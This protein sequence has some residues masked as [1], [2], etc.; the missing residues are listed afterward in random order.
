MSKTKEMTV[1]T[2][3]ASKIGIP[4]SADLHSSKIKQIA[5]NDGNFIV[6]QSASDL[7]KANEILFKFGS[8]DNKLIDPANCY[9][10][11]YGQI[12]YGDGEVIPFSTKKTPAGGGA[13]TEE[14]NPNAF[15]FPINAWGS[16]VFK[17]CEVSV[18]DTVV[19]AS[20]NLYAYKG[21]IKKTLFNDIQHKRGCLTLSGYTP[22]EVP[23]ENEVTLLADTTIE[24]KFYSSVMNLE[25]KAK[26][27]MS[28]SLVERH[29]YSR[30]SKPFWAIDRIYE[31]IFEQDKY[32]P[33]GTNIKLLFTL[34]KSEFLTLTKSTGRAYRFKLTDAFLLVKYVDVRPSIVKQ[35]ED[36]T[37]AGDSFRLPLTKTKM[38][39]YT[40]LR[41]STELNRPG[42][43]TGQ[44]P[45][46]M[47]V[48]LLDEKAFFGAS[49]KD[50][51]NFQ[52]FNLQEISI[53]VNGNGRPWPAIK[54]NY[55]QEDFLLALF[56]L[57][58]AV[59]GRMNGDG[60]ANGISV[61]R[62]KSG[63]V[64]YGFPLTGTGDVSGQ[65]LEESRNVNID[66]N[67]TLARPSQEPIAVIVYIEYDSEIVINRQK[68]VKIV[69]PGAKG[70]ETEESN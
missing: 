27:L 35:M 53:H 34:N 4:E 17:N 37:E 3:G 30:W 6:V 59:G 43:V 65:C 40:K 29:W 20:N 13:A 22:M 23:F 16:S 2:D 11:V 50:P 39:Y 67:I 61:D 9:V 10:A 36:L 47:I 33:P 19:N 42:I 21:Y 44:K 41:G 64:F 63:Y 25:A 70:G 7:D 45:R 54:C 5:T 12:I 38:L 66:L 14:L 48:G 24:K 15:V 51:Y 68:K 8:T 1:E 58:Q 69:E 18:N 28:R 31:D 49:G 60:F 62:Y 26:E 56:S 52:H 57:H 55:A 32:L 46:L